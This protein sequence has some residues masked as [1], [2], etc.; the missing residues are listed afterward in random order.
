MFSYIAIAY[1]YI[2]SYRQLC[3]IQLDGYSSSI[4]YLL[5]ASQLVSAWLQAPVNKGSGYAIIVLYFLTWLL[6]L[7]LLEFAAIMP[8]FC[9]LLLPS[10]FSKKSCQQNWLIPSLGLS[11]H[12]T[13]RNENFGL[14]NYI[15][16]Y[17]L[18][19]FKVP[20][21]LVALLDYVF[22]L[23]YNYPH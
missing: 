16:S 7:T 11:Y 19:L 9:S 14:I 5:A 3:V 17:R 15:N 8:A 10:Y 6:Q 2:Y 18:C 20:N 21:I 22:G 12:C 1:S 13:Y 4:N 23:I